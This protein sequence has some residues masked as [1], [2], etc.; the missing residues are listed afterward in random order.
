[1]KVTNLR[2]NLLVGS[3]LTACALLL[4]APSSWAQEADAQDVRKLQTVTVTA[5][6]REQSLQDVSASVTAVSPELLANQHIDTLEDLQVVVP[7]LTIGNDFAFA[8]IFVRGIGLN[9]SLPGMDPSV[10]LHVD[11]AVV[12]QASQQFA[13][14]YDLER[15][16]VIRGPQGTPSPALSPRIFRAALRCAIRTEKAMAFTRVPAKIS[17][18]RT[19]LAFAVS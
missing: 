12:S 19:S 1:M 3:A 11:G 2:L 17:T 5:A 7:G 4:P 9:S 16:E 10:A 13:S 18:M 15:V 14:L 8:K 6:K